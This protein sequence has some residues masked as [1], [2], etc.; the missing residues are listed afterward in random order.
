[1]NKGKRAGKITNMTA[2]SLHPTAIRMLNRIVQKDLNDKEL[3]EAI[4]PVTPEEFH[5]AITQLRKNGFIRSE[6]RQV[7]ESH[8]QRVYNTIPLP[9][10]DDL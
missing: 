1:M 10:H 6:F 5:I 9:L 7:P 4:G 3:L 8:E 2:E